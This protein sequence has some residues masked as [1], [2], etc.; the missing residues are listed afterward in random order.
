MVAEARRR[1]GSA[2]F[3]VG[4]GLDLAGFA[5]RSLDLVLAVDAFPYLVLADVVDRHVAEAGR[6]LRDGGSL[7][8][9]GWS[10]RGDPAL[11]RA[12]ALRLAQAHG[13]AALRLGVRAFAAWDARAFHLRR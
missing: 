13:F 2:R 3:E 10:Y 7:V 12:D 9:F 1:C 5:D 11:D 4:S 6:V 8:V